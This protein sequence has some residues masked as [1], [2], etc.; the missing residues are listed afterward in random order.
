MSAEP[1]FE[2]VKGP[3][4]T[5]ESICMNCLLAVGICSVESE[6]AAREQ[7][8]VCT[9]RPKELAL[10]DARSNKAESNGF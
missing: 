1:H 9:S 2:H 6:L 7:L 3:D 5:F 10:L 8:H 4:A